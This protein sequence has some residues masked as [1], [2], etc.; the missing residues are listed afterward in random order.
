MA[1]VSISEAARLAGI[2]RPTI[3]KLMNNGQLNFTSVV[4]A[5][6][7]VK[8]ID[9]SELI[10]VFG[11]IE[12]LP[13]VTGFTVKTDQEITQ[14]NTPDL[15]YLQHKIELLQKENEGL[16]EAVVSR[17]EHISS[18]RQAMLLL[19]HKQDTQQP[20]PPPAKWWQFWK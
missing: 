10:R 15:Q 19:E 2:S 7:T 11:T 4:K 13:A 16:K 12:N 18:L 9:T 6:R 17:D 3:Y 1:K 20:L 14:V 8:I 5:G